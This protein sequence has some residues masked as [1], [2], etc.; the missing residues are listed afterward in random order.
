MLTGD[1][2]RISTALLPY[3]TALQIDDL[4]TRIA[5]VMHLVNS[6][7]RLWR[8]IKGKNS[9]HGRVGETRTQ[10]GLFFNDEN[11]FDFS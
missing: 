11:V 7:E 8:R 6:Y 10:K 5:M 3:T 4:T 1:D 2:E 9:M